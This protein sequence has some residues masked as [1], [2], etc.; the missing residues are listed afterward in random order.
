MDLQ[1]AQ[2]DAFYIPATVSLQERQ[3]RTL[4]SGD[5]F[6]VFD[7]S[8]NILGGPGS[9]DGVYFRDTRH[10]CKL[11]LLLNGQRPML[12]SSTLRDDNAELTCD[13][14][15][16]D[17][18]D[19]GKLILEHDMLHV[20]RSR[21]LWEGACYERLSIR[22]FDETPTRIRLELLFEAD[23][24]DLFES[25]GMHRPR[26]GEQQAPVL[27]PDRVTLSYL[28]LDNQRRST[29]LRFDPKPAYLDG[30]RASFELDVPAGG[31]RLIFLEIACDS[32]GDGSSPRRSFLRSLFDA[33]RRLRA[34]SSQAAAVATSNE[35]F[36]EAMRRSVCDLYMLVTNKDTGPYPYAG[37][38]WFSAAF[39]RDALITAMQTLW[40]DPRI[41]AGVLNYLA[42][43]QATA[44][45]KAADAEP[46]KILHE[47][48]H[49][50]MAMLGEVPFRR[51]YGS[52]DSTPLFVMLAGA[53]LERTGDLAT[54]ARLWLNIEAALH[55]I[56]HWGDPDGDGFVEYSRQTGEGLANQGWKDSYDS[57]SHADG[58]LATGPI[59]LAEVQG[60]AYAARRAAAVI[61]RAL[62]H[63][64]A[65]AALDAA[66]DRLQTA[67][68]AAFWCE[69]LGTYA[70]ALD[71]AKRPCKVHASNAGHLLLAGIVSRERGRQVATQLM[72][73]QMYTGWGIRT[74]GV[75][76]ARYN[77]IS[78]HNGSVWPHDN[79]LIAL[80]MARYG[81]K[82]EVA[83]LFGGM[84]DACKTIDLRRL[85]ELF[86]GFPRRRAEA[87]T[88]YPVA[89]SPQ[90]W[91]ATALPAM[92]QACLGLS[93][94]P[95][96]C[97]V[98]FDRPVLPPS[99]TEVTV[100]NLE[101]NDARISV[102]F[103]RMGDEVAM[104]VLSRTGTIHA[105][106]T[107]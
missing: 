89:C 49:G 20:R 25:R 91:A 87:L 28:G 14:A 94:D 101:L 69:D 19:A 31:R 51:Y 38:P 4:K 97:T 13:L 72:S 106:L 98:R 77:P 9:S 23:F 100:M 96:Q 48:R 36:N 12:L 99:L 74:L 57:I 105:T 50:E 44:I 7:A 46:G 93:F 53:Y 33:R 102:R 45:D 32:A 26:R 95:A 67:F 58:S 2:P 56:E 41:T 68:E 85:P 80:G 103:S 24:T 47:V 39:G 75:N 30:D 81:C 54:A 55:W 6:G 43:N 61:A 15:N 73:S 59:A 90:A 83:R 21:F 52:V 63:A 16:P 71:G 3:T 82:A 27:E 60:Y 92:L 107:S 104:N 22:N 76:A 17:L 86:C 40:L 11:G 8:G 79:S 5:T 10:L 34:E 37:V 88:H 84:F 62:G 18:Y 70:L 29:R 65:A 64:A 66:A 78:Y 35:V 1:A 42:V